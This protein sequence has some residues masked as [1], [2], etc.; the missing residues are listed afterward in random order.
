MT[1]PG[2]GV[3]HASKYA[4]EALSDALRFETRGF[5]IGVSV[6]APGPVLHR[7]RRGGDGSAGGRRA[8]RRV[9]ARR[10]GAQRRG[11]RRADAR[12]TLD[13]EDVAEVIVTALESAG[14]RRA[15]PVGLRQPAD[16]RRPR[17]AADRG[18]GRRPP[19]AV[20]DALSAFAPVARALTV[21]GVTE[22]RPSLLGRPLPRR[23]GAAACGSAR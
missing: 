16:R 18:L 9:H 21:L 2:G 10:R 12:G 4:V 7:V 14:R 19:P 15:Y 22:R 8:V 3:Y 20:P 23:V 17:G 1:L 13:P 11:V 6:V 5:G